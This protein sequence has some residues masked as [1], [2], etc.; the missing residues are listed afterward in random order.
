MNEDRYVAAIEVSSSKVIA[1]VGK[2]H[3]DG[4]LDILSTEQERGVETVKYGIIQNLE[5]TAMRIR[6]VLERLQ[7][8]AVVAPRVITGLYV[9]LSGRSMRS[10]RTE[11]ELN[12]PDDTEITDDVLGC[13]TDEEI[14][15]LLKRIKGL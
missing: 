10:I 2:M 5:E 7:S 6:R 12:L 15:D 13:Q 8:K 1:A 4:R 9:G 11:V 14:R 3:S